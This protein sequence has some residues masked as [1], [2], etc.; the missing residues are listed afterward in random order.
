[1]APV[2]ALRETSM[3]FGVAFARLFLGERP[4]RKGWAAVAMIAGGAA[5]LRAG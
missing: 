4:G 1:M 5:M 3:L 2:A